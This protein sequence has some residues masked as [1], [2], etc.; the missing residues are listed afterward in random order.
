MYTEKNRIAAG[1]GEYF[2]TKSSDQEYHMALLDYLG[3]IQVIF[4]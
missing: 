1:W 2:M 4:M 3:K